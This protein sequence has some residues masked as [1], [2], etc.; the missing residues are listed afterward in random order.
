ALLGILQAMR[1]QGIEDYHEET[2]RQRL[3]MAPNQLAGVTR[4]F[5]H[6]VDVDSINQKKLDS[7]D[8]ATKRYKMETKGRARYIES[9]QKSVLAPETLE[10][11]IGAEVMFVANNF[12][13]GFSNGTRGQ[14]VAFNDEGAPLI[15]LQAKDRVIAAAPHTWSVTEDGATRAEATQLPLRLAWAIT[16]HKSQGM[17]LDSALIDLSR[18]FTPGMGYVALS[19][20]RSLSGL[21]LVGIN[22]MAMRLHPDV[23]EFDRQLQRDSSAHAANTPDY[24]AKLGEEKKEVLQEIDE[25]LFAELKAWRLQRARRD[26]VAPFIIAHNTLLEELC[27]TQPVTPQKLVATKGFGVKKLESYGDEL[28]EILRQNATIKADDKK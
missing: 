26:Q 14:I 18:S 17:S 5:S 3:D 2:L 1:L 6:N 16:I 23:Y 24:H 21:Y 25:N 12:S 15:K 10:L 7:I 11:K 4:L 20:V 22:S 28:L 13:L 27:R 19:R 9:L 8:S